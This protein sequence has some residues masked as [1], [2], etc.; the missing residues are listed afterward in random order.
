MVKSLVVLII[1]LAVL[2]FVGG[3]SP[4]EPE[5]AGPSQ[6]EIEPA[7]VE[8]DPVEV[9]PV[10]VEPAAPEPNEVEPESVVTEIVEPVEAGPD[11][12]QPQAT[13]SFHDKCADTLKDFVNDRGMVDYKRLRRKRYEL[14]LLL[15]E[16]DKLGPDEYKSWPRQDRV[17]FWINTYNLQ[18]LKVVV[19][20]YPI[21]PTSRILA[22]YWGPLNVRHIEGKI[23]RHKFLVM[24][25]Q[26][27]FAEIERRFFRDEF[28]DH[29]IFFAL[30]SASLSSP[31]LRNEP[32]YGHKLNEQLEDQVERFLSDPLAFRIDRE[33]R[34]VYLSA[35]FELLSH[36]KEFVGKFATDK[37]F[38][39]HPPPTRAALNFITS[40]ISQKDISFLEVGNYSVKYM[41]HDWTINDGS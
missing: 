14:R 15:E 39:D 19:D 5:L 31:A 22:V 6:V 28:D 35:M 4:A 8:P 41:K 32:Y 25:E 11:D 26:F 7:Q 13:V 36:G 29:R 20:N 34:N 10:Y 18:K 24:G 27:T 40:Y 21:T 16:F 30:T 9:K 33:R 17:A 12:P 1:S 3:C 2:V 23:A 37:K 38:K